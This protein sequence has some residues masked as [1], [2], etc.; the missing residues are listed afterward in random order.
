MRPGLLGEAARHAS[1]DDADDH[2]AEALRRLR[3][4]PETEQPHD[5]S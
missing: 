3:A 1:G 5:P 4:D 2:I